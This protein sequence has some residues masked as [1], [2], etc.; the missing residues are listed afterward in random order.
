MSPILLRLTIRWGRGSNKKT[1]A[2]ALFMVPIELRA[3]AYCCT[4]CGSV[5]KALKAVGTVGTIVG[6]AFKTCRNCRNCRNLKEK[7]Q[8]E[9]L[10]TVP[11]VPTVPTGFKAVPT[12]VSTVPM[13]FHMFLRESP[14]ADAAGVHG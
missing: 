12:M 7:N 13:Y 4:R 11:T 2:T 3:K 5:L 10:L 6:T 8:L 14:C 9:F 1:F